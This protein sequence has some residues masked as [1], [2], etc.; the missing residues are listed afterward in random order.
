MG[1]PDNLKFTEEHEWAR[2]EDGGTITV[3]ITTHAQ[4]ALGDV[5]FVELPA[6]GDRVSGGQPFGVVESVKTVSDLYSPCDGEVVAINEGLT[7]APEQVN[8]E[9]YGAGWMIRLR[10]DAPG[11]IDHLMDAAAY[12]AFTANV[13]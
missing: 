13:H 3:G 8:A 7:D 5:V 12:D 1:S 4:D 9:A 11:A 6:V 2:L 10:P